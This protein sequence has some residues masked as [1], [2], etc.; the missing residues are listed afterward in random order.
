MTSVEAIFAV[1]EPLFLKAGISSARFRYSR[2][3]NPPPV[4]GP[5]ILLS[6]NDI[7]DD[8]FSIPFDQAAAMSET[9]LK[10]FVEAA[11]QGDQDDAPAP[12]EPVVDDN[13]HQQ[14]G[15][16]KREPA[17]AQAEPSANVAALNLTVMDLNA[18]VVA[19][20]AAYVNY[21]ATPTSSGNKPIPADVPVPF[22][23]S[24]Y[25]AAR[26]FSPLELKLLE[27]FDNDLQL[28]IGVLN[29]SNFLALR[30]LLYLAG[31][32][33]AVR[34]RRKK[35]EEIQAMFVGVTLPL[36]AS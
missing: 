29:A 9:M 8:V 34:F 18:S 19:I 14:D 13:G 27:L 17:P 31:V 2:R 5:V 3:S 32:S 4:R 24:S 36:A 21:F 26:I 23:A 11:M 10:A 12:R 6:P 7:S 35:P 30:T 28:T 22:T 15:D 16:E 20:V 1:L 25:E 33:M